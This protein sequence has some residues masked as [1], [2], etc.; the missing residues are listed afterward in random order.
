[1]DKYSIEADPRANGPCLGCGIKVIGPAFAIRHSDGGSLSPYCSRSC[2]SN[3]AEAD[4]LGADFDQ[5]DG[6]DAIDEP[7]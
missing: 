7:R 1:M 5:D 6:V 3:D 2:A 4:V